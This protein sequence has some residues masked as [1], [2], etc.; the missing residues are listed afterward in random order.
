MNPSSLPDELKSDPWA[1]KRESLEKE[2]GD[3]ARQIER[4]GE[5][6]SVSVDEALLFSNSE[7]VQSKF[8]GAADDKLVGHLQSIKE[9]P[10][11]IEEAFWAVLTRLPSDE[12]RVTFQSF[13]E[14]RK[15]RRTEGIRQMVWV[16]I[17]SSEMRFNY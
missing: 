14:K 10:T 2:S 1:K 13:L 4:P 12:E 3:F 11:L 17:C 6:F 5:N 7:E 8:L 9:P 15:D 16:L